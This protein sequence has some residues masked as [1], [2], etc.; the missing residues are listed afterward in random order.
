LADT[1]P[2]AAT[3]GFEGWL[4]GWLFAGWLIFAAF[5]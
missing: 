4:S 1:S 3:P 2:L 5:H